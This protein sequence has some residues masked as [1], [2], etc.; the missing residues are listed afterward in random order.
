MVT[1]LAD[2]Q[3]YETH[4]KELRHAYSAYVSYMYAQVGKNILRDTLNLCPIIESFRT[5]LLKKHHLFGSIGEGGFEAG[6]FLGKIV[7]DQ[8]QE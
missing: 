3:I 7:S 2:S 6:Y 1:V 8:C 4:A 5:L